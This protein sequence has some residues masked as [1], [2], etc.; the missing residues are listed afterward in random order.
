MDNNNIKIKTVCPLGSEC[1]KLNPTEKCIERCAWYVEIVGTDQQGK[2]HNSWKC[3][4]A[5]QPIL[6]LEVAGTNRGQ[7]EALASFRDEVVLGS[8]RNIENKNT[9]L[10]EIEA[11][12]F[13]D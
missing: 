10:K 7:T 6:M 8:S 1:E 2:E 11:S 4:M 3:S 12:S 13:A 5:W 9:K